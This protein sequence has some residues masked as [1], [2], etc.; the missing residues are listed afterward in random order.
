MS[1]AKN[2]LNLLSS[3]KYM[4]GKRRSRNNYRWDWDVTSAPTSH[5]IMSPKTGRRWRWN[6]IQGDVVADSL[7]K[8]EAEVRRKLKGFQKLA[9]IKKCPA[10][11]QSVSVSRVETRPS[12]VSSETSTLVTVAREGTKIDVGAKLVWPLSLLNCKIR[13]MLPAIIYVTYTYK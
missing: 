7:R 9:K 8:I 5:T 13:L 6:I 10:D 4:C 12:I 1:P 3:R 2:P 11:K